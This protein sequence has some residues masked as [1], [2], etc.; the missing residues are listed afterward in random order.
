MR[1]PTTLRHWLSV[2]WILCCLCMGAAHA[3]V[4]N[5]IVLDGSFS[6]L[7][8]GGTLEVLTES[9]TSAGI[10]AISKKARASFSPVPADHRFAL[11]EDRTVWVRLV[12]KKD[13]AAPSEWTLHV[14]LPYLDYAALYQPD[15]KGGWN[16]QVAGDTIAVA[17]WNHPSLYPDF[18]ITL[19]EQEVHEAYLE[20]R[21]FKSIALPLQLVTKSER[22]RQRELENLGLGVLIGML[23]MLIG[24]CFIHYLQS[25]DRADGWYTAYAALVLV[26][27]ANITG[28]AAL[29]LWPTS[30]LWS[31]FAHMALPILGVGGT[32][33]FVRHIASLDVG[34]P[35]L[36]K[37]VY[38][39]GLTSLPVALLSI[40]IDRRL[41]L[42]VNSVYLLA[43]PVLTILTA[44]LT[45]RRGYAV[46]KW[47]LMAYLPQCAVVLLQ[48]LQLWFIVPDWWQTRYLLV[49]AI[50]MMVPLLQQALHTRI[51]ERREAEERAK[52]L[53]A[54]DALTG[55]LTAP[56][57]QQQV[58]HALARARHDSEPSAI[59]LVDVVNFKYLR[60]SYGDAIAEQ[61]LLRAAVKLHRVLRDVDPAGRLDSARFGLVLDGVQ[62]R[63]ALTERMV[64][65]IASGLI[66]LPGLKPEVTLQFHVACVL[67][68]EVIPDPRTILEEL[69]NVLEGISPRTR[70]PIRFLEPATTLPAPLSS[71]HSA[72]GASSEMPTQPNV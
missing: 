26:I 44:T 16:K 37:I 43:G 40:A 14:P 70:R 30:P 68:S 25:Q 32:L 28:L 63:Q 19:P 22:D 1:R 50:A 27:I 7:Q 60:D 46:S 72:H 51:R 36:A 12:L 65:L 69:G 38:A 42:N 64:R 34:F 71:M 39:V 55:L 24:V 4:T 52:A 2:C 62:D 56:L 59:V 54:Q 3:Q 66:P 47:L 17:Q 57:L 21:N 67:L 45:W 29:W 15:G 11:R 10:D 6:R 48:V 5:R 9:G 41:A 33:L 58:E 61:C 31:N 20:V 13:A 23:I 49:V 18:D 8:I 35:R 53:P